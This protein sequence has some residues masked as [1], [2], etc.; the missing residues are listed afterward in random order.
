MARI[1]KK[2][3][4]YSVIA[5]AVI[6]ALYAP[7]LSFA[8]EQEA[9]NVKTEIKETTAQ[10][11][12]RLSKN[13]ATNAV[14]IMREESSQKY[15]ANEKFGD[16]ATFPLR[17]FSKLDKNPWRPAP[18]MPILDRDLDCFY[19]V[20]PYR[21]PQKYDVNTTPINV[22]ADKLQGTVNEDLL[23]EGNVVITQAD[24]TLTA[25]KTEYNQQ[26]TTL[27]SEGNVV[28]SAPEYTLS[29]QDKVVSNIVTK[30]TTVTNASFLLNGS[31]GSGTA[32][33]LELD[34]EAETAYIKEFTFTG[35]PP[36]DKMWEVTASDVDLENGEAFGEAYN[37]TLRV[38]GVP[39]LWTPYINFPISNERKT[40][41]LYPSFAYSSNR[42]FDYSQPIYFNIA[43]N[44][45][46]TFTPRI[47]GFRGLMLG[48]EFRYM[49][50]AG[51]SGSLTFDFLPNDRRW[52][53]AGDNRQRWMFGINHSSSFLD[54]DLN[55]RVDYKRIK[56]NDYDYLSDI[57]SDSARVTD[58][59]LVQ[60]LYS[61]YNKENY[62]LSFE[63]RE[64]QSLLPDYA[65]VIKPFS[66]LPQLKASYYETYEN[67]LLRTDGEFTYFN[68]PNENGYKSFNTSRFHLEPSATYMLYN[69]RGTEL[70][71]GGRLFLTHYEQGSLD[72]LPTYYRRNLGF[73]SFDSS[74]DRAL[75]LLEMRG[76]TTLERKVFD[77]RH[78]QTLE[79]EIQY[80]FIPYK[81][82]NDI[83]LYDTSDRMEDYYSNFSFRR[84][85]GID[86]IADTNAVTAGITSRILDP[87]DREMYRIAL[88]QTYSFVPT[89]VT[90]N[91]SDPR[92]RYPSSPLSIS[93]DASPIE[94]LTMHGMVSYDNE[95]NEVTS[96]N[97]M[98]EYASYNGLKA[99]LSYRFAQDGNR[100]LDNQIVDLSQIGMLFTIPISNDFKVIG[101]VYRDLEQSENIDRKLALRYEDC[102]Y[103]ITLMVED[104]NTTDWSD[105]SRDHEKRY[106]IQFELKGLGAINVSGDDN[107]ASTDTYLIDPFNPTNLNR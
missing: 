9:F 40:G 43:P 92:T 7:C 80:R 51:T 18:F 72:S 21:E 27:T 97:A 93:I 32:G 5:T 104:Y 76:K 50:I 85:A 1:G 3:A 64:Y 69:N 14:L 56:P 105:L 61:S 38:A 23:Y 81:N 24:T 44:Y 106:G 70:S 19:G 31:V 33:N 11:H 99:Q 4:G 107:P 100:S 94:P 66:M 82:Q 53:L 22:T 30:K 48:N 36:D 6:V 88:S 8:Q 25:D 74:A 39:V 67:L 45:D 57:G 77:L 73:K 87:H 12:V 68:A 83:G 13:L 59:H 35:C 75:Y 55:V 103:A 91:P 71:A 60:S 49:P 26:N 89:R 34:N 62:D 15:L 79:P 20:P 2:S 29:T 95:T 54:N 65:T 63:L 47:M 46:Y 41:L 98:T 17:L 42:G 84:F 37:A 58:N 96:W 86:R 90:L 52:D 78:T 16:S 28:Y 102:C 10:R 101:A